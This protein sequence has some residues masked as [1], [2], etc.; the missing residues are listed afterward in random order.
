MGITKKKIGRK[1]TKHTK[2]TMVCISHIEFK[3]KSLGSRRKEQGKGATEREKRTRERGD[4]Y[5]E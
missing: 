1:N 3:K 5:K 4:K 2:P